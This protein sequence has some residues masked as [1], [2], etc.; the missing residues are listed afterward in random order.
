MT[1]TAERL[2][3]DSNSARPFLTRLAARPFFAANGA[4]PFI[5]PQWRGAG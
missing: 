5:N 2:S 4:L 3:F 1:L